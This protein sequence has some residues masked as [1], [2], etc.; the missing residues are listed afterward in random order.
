MTSLAQTHPGLSYQWDYT[1]NGDRVP[2]DFTYGSKTKVWW[3]CSRGHSWEATIHNRSKRAATGCPFC[4]GN[5]AIPGVTDLATIYPELATEWNDSVDIRNVLPT[6]NKKYQWKCARGHEWASSAGNRVYG[7]GCPYCGN[8]RILAGFNDLATT[9]PELATEIDQDSEI[10][11]EDVMQG[12]AKKPLW[13]CTNGHTWYASVYSRTGAGTGCPKC[14]DNQNP[15]IEQ[16]ISNALSGSLL[17][18][19]VTTWPGTNRPLEVD[20]LLGDLVVEYDGFWH[21]NREEADVRKTEILIDMG[22]TVVRIRQTPLPKLSISHER[23]VQIP[24][25]YSVNQNDLDDVIH[26][27]VQ[28]TGH[29]LK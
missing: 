16:N 14:V 20:I 26:Q 19:T 24:F 29:R 21:A 2:S 1:L 4:K 11:A 27:I 28:L 5:V 6:S 23:L 7:R 3:R 22:Y 10:S 8:R 18:Q 17:H 9:H 12:S 13:R 25:K 15:K